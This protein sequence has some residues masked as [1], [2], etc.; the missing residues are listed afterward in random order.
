M[1]NSLTLY[2]R[3]FIAFVDILGF[4]S[5]V[6]DSGKN[7]ATEIATIKL[8]SSAIMQAR[9]EV[10]ELLGEEAGLAFT[11]FSDSFVVSVPAD[12][13]LYG[14]GL[15]TFAFSILSIVDCFLESR[16]LLRGG[17]SCGKLVHTNNLLFGPAMNRAY[18]LESRLAKYP[19]I[20]LDP[21]LP[22][23]ADKILPG[24]LARDTDELLYLNYFAPQKAVYLVPMWLQSIQQTI[25]AIPQTELLFEKRTWLVQKYNQALSS[26]SYEDFKA[27][28]NGYVD[29]TDSN[30]A[31]V[32]DQEYLLGFAKD[33]HPL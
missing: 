9:K 6:A 28:L 24:R 30:N 32:E 13:G 3:R 7:E 25:E 16:L 23:T 17:I 14:R 2:E 4:G 22:E 1:N 8:V 5:L 27:R 12:G 18:E 10:E 15:H 29:D 19:R 11:Q 21:N 33:L 20:I 31:V 26:F